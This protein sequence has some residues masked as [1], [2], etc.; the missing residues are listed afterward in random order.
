[1]FTVYVYILD[2]FADWELGYVIAELNSRRFFK[3]NAPSVFYN[4]LYHIYVLYHNKK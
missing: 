4:V 2:T 3:E 1:M